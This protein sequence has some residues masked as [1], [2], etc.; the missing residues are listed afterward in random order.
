MIRISAP[1][2]TRDD[3]LTDQISKTISIPASVTNVKIQVANRNEAKLEV[4]ESYLGWQ[5]NFSDFPP[6]TTGGVSLNQIVSATIQGI[7]VLSKSTGLLLS[8]LGT[9]NSFF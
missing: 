7:R 9:L 2:R 4:D 3:Q 1:F 5:D 8:D 6:D